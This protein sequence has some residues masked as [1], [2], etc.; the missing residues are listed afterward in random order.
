MFLRSNIKILRIV[1]QD[2]NSSLILFY[3]IITKMMP[4]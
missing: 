3:A 1:L 4:L 2:N